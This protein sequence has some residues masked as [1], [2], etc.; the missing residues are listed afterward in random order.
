MKNFILSILLW[1]LVLSCTSTT[2]IVIENPP[3]SVG[4]HST[5]FITEVRMN[6]KATFLTMT[7][8]FE[9]NKWYTVSSETYIVVNGEKHIVKSVDGI[10]FDE[11][12]KADKSGKAVFTLEFDAIDPD[13]KQ[14]DFLESDCDKCFKIWG[15]ELKSDVLTNRQEVPQEI[16]DAAIVT[17]DG[18]SLE[19]PQ[20]KAGKATIKGKYIGYVPDMNWVVNIRT[21]DHITG[22]EEEFG[23]PVM[24]DGSF[25]LQV[26]M[27]IT[28]QVIFSSASFNDCVL[29]SPDEETTIYIDLQQ[30]SCQQAQ[31]R[32]DKCP[33]SKYV[34]FGG[35]NAEINNQFCD[36]N[37]IRDVSEP[38]FN[39][40]VYTEISGMSSE[41]YKSY[42]LFKMNRVKK[43]LERKG[44]TKKALELAMINLRLK[45]SY[46]L[47]SVNSAMTSSYAITS[48]YNKK[49][50]LV[51]YSPPVLD[52]NYFSFLKDFGINR[53]KN[54]YSI[55]F[56]YLFD[57]LSNVVNK[58]VDYT[59]VFQQ[60]INKGA[61]DSED[62]EIAEYIKKQ[63][64]KDI[65][66]EIQQ[67]ITEF[68]KKYSDIINKE[69]GN[70][71]TADVKYY[72]E[73]TLETSEGIIF[74]L[75]ETQQLG[76]N[77]AKNNPLIAEEFNK[78]SKMKN[79][80]YYEHFKEKNNQLLNQIEVGKKEKSTQ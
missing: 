56:L 44:L 52:E 72:L 26:P 68:W 66:P 36:L 77:I 31:H 73:N 30:I 28:T 16:K 45:A 19:T 78:L 23:T 40:Q 62:I 8:I 32:V 63:A 22:M 5:V 54:L 49:D 24:E 13:A 34:Y 17:E 60:L 46:C 50:G 48:Y 75:L 61:I 76:Y 35:A 43:Q 69:S 70:I 55:D 79:R 20:F 15:V 14:L 21:F 27:I 71:T 4:T 59:T 57:K 74:D 9:P 7:I 6:K 65:T 67:K 18:K 58:S 80:I 1:V 12:I 10:E 38:F 51:G 64:F 25:E 53:Q 39:E 2:D 3:F 42:I 41:K 11:K 33:E 47:L 29:L 37:V